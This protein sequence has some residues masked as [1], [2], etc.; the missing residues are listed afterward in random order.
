MSSVTSVCILKWN[1]GKRRACS[2]R[3]SRNSHCG[4]ITM[5]IAQHDF[6]PPYPGADFTN[7]LLVRPL[8]KFIKH[9]KLV[10]HFESRRMNR[11]ATEVAQKV[12]VLLQNQ[13]LD[14]GPCQQVP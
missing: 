14:S 2:A 7:L 6:I 11:V 9:S 12:S 10:H 1:V 5:N 13:D 3:K 4:I 8:Q